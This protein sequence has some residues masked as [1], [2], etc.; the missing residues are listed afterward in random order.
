[1]SFIKTL[2]VVFAIVL[3]STLGSLRWL[4]STTMHGEVVEIP[5]LKLMS[6]AQAL[7]TL[8]SLGLNYE[9]IDSTHYV[10][11][12]PKG[13]VIETFPKE[14]AAVKLG[15]KI[16]LSTN[17]A[18]LPKH[19]LPNFKDQLSSYVVSK[20]KA[21]GFIIDSIIG[22]PDLSHDLVLR[23]VDQD[24][25]NAEE[26]APYVTGSR[27]KIYVSAGLEGGT[28]FLPNLIGMTYEEAKQALQQLSLN[29]GG[30][31]YQG[32]ESDTMG[33]YILKSFPVYEPDAQ[34][35]VGSAID[36]W[37]VSD[38]TLLPQPKNM[39]TLNAEL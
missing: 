15:R 33:S 16:L 35:K 17:P 39:D 31:V 25:K 38:A 5:N 20:F 30:I 36:L 8:D 19:P 23:V 24:N 37:L 1:M 18:R 4:K 12:I 34:V 29:E 22:V 10:S 6:L 32:V 3:V 21:K 13:A 27:F 14:Y 9:V 7:S 26:Q 28:V 11:G 2:A